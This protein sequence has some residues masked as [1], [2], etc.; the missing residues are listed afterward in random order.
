MKFSA[1]LL[2]TIALAVLTGCVSPK[3]NYRPT[4]RDIS[5][6]P[7][8]TV[9][10]AEIGDELVKQGT[11]LEQDALYLASPVKIR[12]AYVIEP[13]NYVKKG[14]DGSREYYVPS[15]NGADS[16][17]IT[18]AALADPW[19]YVSY[20]KNNDQIGIVTVFNVNITSNANGNVSLKKLPS[21]A[22]NSLQQT[23]I[24]SGCTEGMLTLGYREFSNDKA[25]P[26]FNKDVV[27]YDLNSSKIIGY[28]GARIEVIE[29]DNKNI[30]YKVLSNF[31]SF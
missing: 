31:N 10:V 6:P 13:G 1:L 29:A 12:W 23:L 2:A 16:G 9:V 8:D 17:S 26:A 20:K 3:M 21:L 15:Y 22:E 30:T 7:L 14:D 5:F 4:A 18:K 28:K 11:F 19:Q 27:E 24:Y 25:R